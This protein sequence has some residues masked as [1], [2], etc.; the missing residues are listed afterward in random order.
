MQ[1]SIWTFGIFTKSN[2][3]LCFVLNGSNS[4]VPQKAQQKQ[5][6]KCHGFTQKMAATTCEE[7]R[8]VLM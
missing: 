1:I 6:A 4:A 3:G 7:F 5:S 2:F 8:M